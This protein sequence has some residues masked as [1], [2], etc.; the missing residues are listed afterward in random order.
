MLRKSVLLMI[1]LSVPA[2]AQTLPHG[3][4]A[5]AAEPGGKDLWIV[6]DGQAPRHVLSAAEGIFAA[7]WSPDAVHAVCRLQRG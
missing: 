4:S 7:A 5:L 6:V 1:M 2:T 3:C